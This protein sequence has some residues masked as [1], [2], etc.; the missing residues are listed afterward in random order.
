M[1]NSIKNMLVVRP[2]IWGNL[3]KSKWPAGQVLSDSLLIEK[4]F[5]RAQ[6]KCMARF[7]TILLNLAGWR[8][9]LN[10]VSLSN[11]MHPVQMI[12]CN[13]TWLRI[14]NLN[15][16]ISDYCKINPRHTQHLPVQSIPQVKIF[17]KGTILSIFVIS[18]LWISLW[19]LGKTCA[20]GWSSII[21]LKRKLTFIIFQDVWNLLKMNFDIF[22]MKILLWRRKQQFVKPNCRR[23]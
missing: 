6:T 23:I 11:I 15:T 2:L 9:L 19:F 10:R 17:S 14:M 16:I 13:Y 3:R 18:T 12:E 8:L 21:Q 7:D 20:E 4:Y 22:V 1:I 5:Y